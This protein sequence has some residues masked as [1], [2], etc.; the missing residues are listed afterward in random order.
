MA[1]AQAPK[2]DISPTFAPWVERYMRAHGLSKAKLADMAHI[3]VQTLSRL[4]QGGSVRVEIQ[5]FVGLAEAMNIELAFLLH[6]AGFD[7][8]ADGINVPRLERVEAVANAFSEIQDD[9]RS[10]MVEAA[11]LLDGRESNLPDGSIADVRERVIEAVAKFDLATSRLRADGYLADSPVAVAHAQR[12]S[13]K[14]KAKTQW[15]EDEDAVLRANPNMRHT[16]LAKLLDRSED[17]VRIRRMRLT[18]E[19]MTT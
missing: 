3:H 10:A 15:T 19:R 18:R 13:F 9:C 5:T 8:G 12:P 6:K 7:I 14:S 2:S 1:S 4:L 17:A 11:H 16:E